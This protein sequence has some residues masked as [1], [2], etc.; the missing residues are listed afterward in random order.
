[1]RR[2]SGV[3]RALDQQ[4]ALGRTQYSGPARQ[5]H[6]ALR[7]FAAGAT[8]C[9]VTDALGQASLCTVRSPVWRIPPAARGRGKKTPSATVASVLVDELDPC[10]LSP[11]MR[12]T[13]C[14]PRRHP[15][16]LPD[17]WIGH[18]GAAMGRTLHAL[19]GL[20]AV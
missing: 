15:R 20:S 3:V 11:I 13:G 7:Q 9:P 19:P 16:T 1:M 5:C 17:G 14:R 4:Q 12:T 18:T 8:W 6:G 2:P 10:H